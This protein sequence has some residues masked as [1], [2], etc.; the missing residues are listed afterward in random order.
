MTIDRTFKLINLNES[1]H[2]A[3]LFLSPSKLSAL[4]PDSSD[5]SLNVCTKVSRISFDKSNYD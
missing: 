3:T 2:I 5:F 4:I 1:R